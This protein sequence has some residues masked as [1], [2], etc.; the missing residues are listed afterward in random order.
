MKI[1]ELLLLILL[2]TTIFYISV[3]IYNTAANRTAQ[4]ATM[5]DMTRWSQAIQLYY[6][7]NQTSPKNPAGPLTFKKKIIRQLAPYLNLMRL[8]DWWGGQYLIW[9]GKGISK[10]GIKMSES[11]N[12]IISSF[13]EDG[14]MEFWW[15]DPQNRKKGEYKIKNNDDFKKDIIIFN[16]QFIRCPK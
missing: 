9:I 15:Y 4:K 10:Y 13:G 7:E 12:F 1:Y 14:V 11:T 6:L 3:P 2:I 8:E 16:G 5:K